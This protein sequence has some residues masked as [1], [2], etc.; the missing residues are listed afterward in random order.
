MARIGIFGGSFNPV[1]LAHLILAEHA[2]SQR[3]LDRILFVPAK[4][5]PHKPDEPLASDEHRM[6]MLE[7]AIEGNPAFQASALEL[8]RQGP[9]YTLMT[10]RQLRETVER[11]AQLFLIVGGDSLHDIHRW[12]RAAELV[13]EVQIIALDRPGYAVSEALDR[14]ARLFGQEVASQIERL[15]VDAPL[16]D[17]SATEIRE[18]V[19]AGKSI[20]DMVP[21]PVRQYIVEN[22]LYIE[23]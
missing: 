19:R 1:H 10:V 22:R 16:L 17:I 14:I 11:E 21:E 7:L 4:F 15:K 5:P 3:R 23:A 20:R 2:R 12:W 9:S 6:R 8:E 13:R 18:R